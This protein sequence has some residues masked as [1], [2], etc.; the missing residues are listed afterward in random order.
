MI[1]SVFILSL[2]I[3]TV[4]F[5]ACQSDHFK[6]VLVTAHRGAS[7]LAPENTMVS[8]LLSMK[9]GADFSE[10]DVQETADGELILM[11]D[12]SLRRTTNKKAAVWKQDLVDLKGVDAGSWFSD[13]FANEPIPTLRSIIDSVKGK[14]KLNI[15]LK[16][17][18]HQEKLAERTVSLTEEKNFISQCIVTSFDRE[19]IRKVKE[20][21]PNIKTGYILGK[22]PKEDIWS[23][24][25][26]LLSVNQ[27]LVTQKLID[28]AHQ[29]GKEVHVWT[30]NKAN[31]MRELIDLGVDNIITNYPN[32]LIE[33]LKEGK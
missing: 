12:D 5:V 17:N 4:G 6:K 11:H 21:N 1:K 32:V 30:V 23:A 29:H 18:G 3:F 22:M 26:D 25:F 31:K 24:E 8:V 16:L 14:M 7:G 10:I 9:M 19:T 15:E 33:I 2:V 28:E 20:L 27:K 13:E